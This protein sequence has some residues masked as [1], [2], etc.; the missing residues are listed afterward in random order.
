[1]TLT[2]LYIPLNAAGLRS[3]STLGSLAGV[4]FRAHAVT[5][6]L[7]ASAPTA[8]QDELEYAALND[9]ARTSGSLLTAGESRRIVA[10]ADVSSDHVGSAAPV[11]STVGSAVSISGSV[12]LKRIASF[13]VGGDASTDLLWYDV[14]ELPVVLDL[15]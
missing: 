13:H 5:E 11:D 3:L 8:N 7:R 2:R 1:M 15:L 4:P 6:S 12:A 9:A 14:T 10:A